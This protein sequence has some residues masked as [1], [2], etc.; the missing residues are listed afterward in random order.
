MSV[1]FSYFPKGVHTNRRVTDITRRVDFRQTALADPYAFQPFQIKGDDRAEDIAYYYYG[2]VAFTWLVWLSNRMID[3]YF[4]WPMSNENF[5][6]YFIKK[7][8]EQSG[9]TGQQVIEWGLNTTI[10][11]N[12]AFYRNVNDPEL[13]IYKDTYRLKTDLDLDEWDP[14][15]YYDYEQEL[16]DD[17]RVI[18]LIDKEYTRQIVKEMTE[19]L[20]D[21]RR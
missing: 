12:I 13:K 6:R 16:N 2:D 10:T 14:I 7:Y 5:D 3:P 4:E 11:D 21:A 17:R 1:Y 20:N 18:Q 19:L 8:A 9:E 15:R